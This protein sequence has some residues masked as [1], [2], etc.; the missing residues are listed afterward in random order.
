MS[1]Y[2]I[3][4]LIVDNKCKE[5]DR[6][7]SYAI[8][9]GVSVEIGHRVIVPFGRGN[10]KMGGYVIGL[11][12]TIDFDESKLKNIIKLAESEPLLPPYIIELAKWIREKYLCYYIEA[13][14][15]ALPA[16]VRIKTTFY[17]EMI[18]DSKKELLEQG[19][20]EP[21]I[22]I[23]EFIESKG[24][25][26]TK[27]ELR[28]CFNDNFL[29]NSL[30]KLIKCKILRRKQS[31]KKKE[32]KKYEKLIYLNTDIYKNIKIAPNAKKQLLALEIIK[33]NPGIS[34]SK[35]L[36]EYNISTYV[37]N[38]LLSKRAI[39]IEEVEVY[40]LSQEKPSKEQINTLTQEQVYAIKA[41][42]ENF[43]SNCHVLLHGVTG[44]GKTEIYLKLIEKEISQ[45]R[46][47]I[48]LVPEISLT[49][50]MIRRFLARFG[51]VVAVIHSGL[52]DGEKYDE[53][54]RIRENKASVVVGARSAI[55]APFRN[56]GIIIIDEE[57]EHTYKSE[58]RPKYDAREI[59]IRRCFNEG[60]N[61]LLGSATPSI[62][63]FY[64]AEN[65]I[66]NFRLV[67]LKNRVNYRPMPEIEIVDM[68]KE[69]KKGNR[70]IF[71]SKLQKNILEKLEANEQIILFLNRRGYSTFVS[72]RNCG[73]VVKCPHCNISLTYHSKGN[74]LSC[75]YCGHSADNPKLC[76]N[77]GSKYIKYFGIGTQKV[78]NE[79]KSNFGNI[80]VLR[81]D[82]DTTTRK[83][84][85][86]KIL[87]KFGNLESNV[88]IGTQ[89]IGKG[90]DFPNVTLVGIISSDTYLNMPDFRAAE[91]TFQMLTQAGG[92][93]GRAALPGQ[94]V[95]QTY[96]PNHYS[97]IH[98]KS[99]DY[100]GFYNDEIKLREEMFYP[101][102]SY[103][104]NII[105]SGFN[106]QLVRKAAIRGGEILKA[107]I[108][109]VN[110]NIEV[111]K[112]T[113]A[114]LSKIRNKYRW[115]IILKSK[116]E[117][118]LMSVLKKF[119][120]LDFGKTVLVGMDINP[121]NML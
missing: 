47:G 51:D 98:A 61:L 13:I 83:N 87:D 56:L 69:L 27:E 33:N 113:K 19:H 88:L 80:D 64:K 34:A 75:H 38:S 90:H 72:C 28:D 108:K 67:S 117:I 29:D 94:V 62:E 46:Q 99:H 41:I 48:V 11:T 57:H 86:K 37:I 85:H 54:R 55:F 21:V 102:F 8:P 103:I 17:Y 14:H 59:A 96:T 121:I 114:P 42:S 2:R 81:M 107:Y 78:E 18:S 116:D 12:N 71:S 118:Q 119:N 39:K 43:E 25:I 73:Y 40:R 111:W 101:P 24:G 22:D 100:V 92:R 84:S 26:A 35:I 60:C 115:Q 30:R 49:P 65:R 4:K 32:S 6:I 79:F 112:P 82:A 66:D 74:Y 77:C 31:I 44:S 110:N 9:R 91:K 10:K 45:G 70:S 58:I 93:A 36:K 16:N 63:T 5:T 1:K 7:Y 53:W 23:L 109:N 15:A 105:F 104:G 120:E 68:R 52:S 97:L 89:M 95:I 20:I 106:E 76:P 3:A 50:Q